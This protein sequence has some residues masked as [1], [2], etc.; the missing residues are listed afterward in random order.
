LRTLAGMIYFST[1]FRATPPG[2]SKACGNSTPLSTRFPRWFRKSADPW[3]RAEGP[4]ARQLGRLGRGGAGARGQCVVSGL[5]LRLLARREKLCAQLSCAPGDRRGLST[6]GGTAARLSA[7]SQ[8]RPDRGRGA[9]SCAPR[10]P[11]PQLA[12]HR[13]DAA[14]APAGS[15]GTDAPRQ[16]VGEMQQE[17][18]S[19][20]RESESHAP[21]C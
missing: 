16:K 5:F 1:G 20:Q 13:G 8:C 12:G 6:R 7:R 15:L 19:R 21:G 18:G 2:V 3:A 10:T 17:L 11:G 14:V 9:S 4:P